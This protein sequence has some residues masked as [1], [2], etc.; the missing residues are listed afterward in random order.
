MM[1]ILM[2]TSEFTPLPSSHPA[3]AGPQAGDA[4]GRDAS[5]AP[6]PEDGRSAPSEEA[7]PATPAEA[8]SVP[9]TSQARIDANRAN[10][11][12]S[13]G[14]RTP[15]GKARV[16]GNALRHGLRAANERL[17]LMD[18]DA[19]AFGHYRGDVMRQ[20]RPDGPVER[21]LARQVALRG[22]RL[23]RCARVEA[24][25]LNRD[26]GMAHHVAMEEL[27]R[28]HRQTWDQEPHPI[29]LGTV[30]G[31]ALAGPSSAY[32]TLRRYE[33]THER[34]F[35]TAKRELERTQAARRTQ[36]TEELAGMKALGAPNGGMQAE[37]PCGGIGE[38]GEEET[39]IAGMNGIGEEEKQEGSLAAGHGRA[40]THEMGVG[41]ANGA[42]EGEQHADLVQS[43]VLDTPVT[44][45]QPGEALTPGS[46][47]TPSA[48]SPPGAKPPAM[49]TTPSAEASPAPGASVFARTNPTWDQ[50]TSLWNSF[51]QGTL[52]PRRAAAAAREG[53]KTARGDGRSSGRG[54]GETLTEA[55]QMMAEDR[56]RCTLEEYIEQCVGMSHGGLSPGATLVDVLAHE[57][58]ERYP[59]IEQDA[60][61]RMRTFWPEQT[62]EKAKRNT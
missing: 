22:W 28:P 46:A 50:R 27:P 19:E 57:N 29:V 33:R 20:Y 37:G 23:E 1:T 44:A 24:A 43:P 38:E 14:P 6:S 32:E 59:G 30:L 36:G 26:L 35:Y 62:G 54:G 51:L 9:A 7:P 52:R 61:R 5:P 11:R 10:A 40:R 49:G 39:G 13:T 41:E 47:P 58:G 8:A 17:L 60:A 18:E 12:R 2:S 45:G 15:E 42:P 34:A 21:M 16:S 3:A 31:E 53:A 56:E 55:E 25:L 4:P 48:S